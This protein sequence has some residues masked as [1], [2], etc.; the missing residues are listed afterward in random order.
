MPEEKAEL[1]HNVF[2][3]WSGGRS[4]FI[5]LAL[6]KLLPMVLQ[7]SKPFMSEK[8][9]DGGRRGLLELARALEVTKVGIV[10]LTPENL[11]AGWL[12]F[13]AGALSKTLDRETRV[14]T[15]LL[16]G[17]APGD[18]P[19]PLGQ[20]QGTV[21][22]KERTAGMFQDINKALGSQVREDNLTELF[23]RMVWPDLEQKL[24][25]MPKP[26]KDAPVKRSQAEM[27]EE[28]LENSRSMPQVRE[29]VKN[30]EASMP[31]RD[32]WPSFLGAL[33]TP[34]DSRLFSL[35]GAPTVGQRVHAGRGALQ[36]WTEMKEQIRP[37]DDVTEDKKE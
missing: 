29:A 27:I 25:S 21:A 37:K 4:K 1:L 15:Y 11:E 2:I 35:I 31:T 17:L 36:A 16:G 8:D 30:I 6:R 3:S 34:S 5:A 32:V 23:D 24:S 12:L 9:I 22:N 18:V 13:E 20:F 10:C 28:I 26:E 7:A 33:E 19:P 14:F